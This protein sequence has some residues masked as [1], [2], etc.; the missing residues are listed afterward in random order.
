[1]HIDW[2]GGQTALATSSSA[3]SLQEG[4]QTAAQPSQVGCWNGIF[5]CYILEI[6][7]YFSIIKVQY[8][9]S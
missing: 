2:Q 4:Q 7:S 8:G 3:V 6:Y 9:H 1:M 5:C